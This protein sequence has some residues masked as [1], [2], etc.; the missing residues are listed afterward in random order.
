MLFDLRSRG[1]RGTVRVVYI[2]L[3]VLIG[4]G[5]VGFGIGGGFGG[6]GILSAG[7]GSEGS[8]SASFANQIKKYRKQTVQNPQ[9][10]AAWEGLAKALL[11]EAGGETQNGLN[12]KGKQL[13][14]ESSEAW[15]KYLA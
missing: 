12:D 2:G 7:T 14:R 5:L 3:A 4:L 13:F 8:N 9:N 11:H 10:A 15:Q 1:R 6:G